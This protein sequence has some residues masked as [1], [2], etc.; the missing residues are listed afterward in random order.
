V[1]LDKAR[2]VDTKPGPVR[3][4]WDA[5]DKACQ[6]LAGWVE[7]ERAK[8]DPDTERLAQ[9][10]KLLVT[11]RTA[12]ASLTDIPAGA[13]VSLLAAAELQDVLHTDMFKAILVVKG[14][15]ASATQLINDRKFRSDKFSILSSA[16]IAYALI[17]HR[18]DGRIGLAGV[19]HG[20]KSFTGTIGSDID[21]PTTT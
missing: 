2:F 19:V 18:D 14:G 1:V 4:A 17:Y 21:L 8:P 15:A 6:E 20:S 9:G 3:E 12:L 5:L 11:C 13:A 7:D 16:S 10:D